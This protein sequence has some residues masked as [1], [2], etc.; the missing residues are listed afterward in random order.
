[1]WLLPLAVFGG[2]LWYGCHSNPDFREQ[3]IDK[4]FLG[5]FT[6]GKEARHRN[7]FPGFYSLNLLGRTLPWAVLLIGILA[8]RAVRAAVRENPV[9]LWLVCWT[10]GGLLFM[11]FV[12]SKRFDRILPVVPPACLLLAAAARYLPGHSLWKMQAVH[13]AILAPLLAI[14]M[15]GGYSAWEV[16][17]GFRDNAGGLVK[18]GHGVRDMAGGHGGRLAVVNGKDEGMVLYT[19]VPHF[20]RMDDA[21]AMWKVGRIDWMVLGESDFSENA[22]ALQPFEVLTQVPK[23]PEKYSGYRLLHRIVPAKSVPQR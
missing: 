20:T 11:E 12:P 13:L 17:K 6:V 18:F 23:L 16:F 10:F 19:G 7:Q 2:W 9:L 1:V 22:I 4:E 3:V 21:K 5:R 8:Q 15:A 14:P